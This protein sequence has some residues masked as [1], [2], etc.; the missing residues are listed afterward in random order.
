M[1]PNRHLLALGLLA[2]AACSQ[3]VQIP[4]SR[5]LALEAPRTV[6]AG[7]QRAR[8][9]LGRHAAVFDP[10]I[11]S[12]NLRY[13]RG[14]DEKIELQVDGTALAVEGAGPGLNTYLGRVGLKVDPAPGEA[15]F[16]GGAGLGL[17]PAGGTMA[18]ADAGLT[19]GIPL[20]LVS[21]FVSGATFI[22][23][24]IDANEIRT[25]SEPG[26][27]DTPTVTTGAGVTLGLAFVRDRYSIAFGVDV[28]S[29]RDE[30]GSE[31]I[32]SLA[33]GF[34]LEL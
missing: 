33:G 10:A 2:T 30:D 25:G 18:S 8:F 9:Q 19:L 1:T 29:L 4:P 13:R 22:S 31:V 34:E 28:T 23:A 3:N 14:L 32:C 5:P 21:P 15:A 6:G 7:V 11:T 17:S 26:D 20:R 16:H 12:G 27:V 24:P